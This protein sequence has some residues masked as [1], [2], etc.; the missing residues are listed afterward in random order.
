[1]GEM[2]HRKLSASAYELLTLIDEATK[3]EG[4]QRPGAKILRYWV[5]KATSEYSLTLKKTVYI[6]GPGDASII[7]SLRRHGLVKQEPLVDYACSITEE[8]ILALEE[9]REKHVYVEGRIPNDATN[10]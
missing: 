8:G 3:W 5:P 9:Y 10:G 2:N 6:S 1:M 7:R 4:D